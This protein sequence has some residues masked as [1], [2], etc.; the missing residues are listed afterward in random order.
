[1]SN[2]DIIQSILKNDISFKEASVFEIFKSIGEYFSDEEVD[3]IMINGVESVFIEKNGTLFEIDTKI[4]EE[5]LVRFL[6]Y[7]S[8]YSSRKI[9]YSNPIFDGKLSCGSRVSIVIE[10]ISQNGTIINIRKHKKLISSLSKLVSTDMLSIEVLKIIE[11]ALLEKKNI[12]ISGGTSSG[13]T[14][15]INAMLNSLDKTKYKNQRVILIE[16]TKELNTNLSH[17]VSLQA[18]LAFQNTE[19]NKGEINMGDLLKASLRLRPDRLIIG[20]VRGSE[21]YYLLHALNT[22]HKGSISSIHANSSRDALRRLETLSILDKNNLNIN[23]VRTW[24]ASNI[25]MVIHL[26]KNENTRRVVEIFNMEGM[27]PNSYIL[28]KIV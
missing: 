20:E 1:M 22:G 12:I 10:P 19:K 15:L 26:E 14:T 2:N 4:K 27:E 16:D 17:C 11:I 25:D 18:R 13:K 7:V 24:I 3:E 28:R 5:E 9:D 8:R 6:D 23:I 21:A